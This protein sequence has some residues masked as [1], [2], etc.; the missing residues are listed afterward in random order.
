MT[1]DNL[2]LIEGADDCEEMI[3]AG[4]LTDVRLDGG[5]PWVT[6]VGSYLLTVLSHSGHFD[7]YPSAPLYEAALRAQKEFLKK[8]V[9]V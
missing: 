3:P 1:R 4:L 9:P 6:L 5:K 7:C 8:H 2:C